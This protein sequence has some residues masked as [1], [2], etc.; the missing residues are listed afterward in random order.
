MTW[1]VA[2]LGSKLEDYILVVEDVLPK[3][4]CKAILQEYAG[5]DDWRRTAIGTGVDVSIRSAWG[6]HI[7]SETII[8]ANKLNR[9][10]LDSAVYAAASKAITAY[11]DAFP[12]CNISSDTGYD[13]LR[14]GVGE[15]Y[16]EHVD[17][18]T[19]RPRAISCSFLLNENYAGG[20]FSFFGEQK[21]IVVPEGGAVLFPSSFLYPHQILPVTQGERY[22]IVTWF[23]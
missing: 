6:I 20:Q 22:S 16:K 5:S 13:I 9:S 21:N 15:F 17:Y 2:M 11:K 23:V 4:I 3:D 1:Q 14:Y 10:F 8:N 7:S 19:E 12:R 18:F